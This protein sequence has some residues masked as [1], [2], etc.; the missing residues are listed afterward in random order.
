M[1]SFVKARDFWANSIASI[2]TLSFDLG[3]SLVPEHESIRKKTGKAG[4]SQA[5]EKIRI[6]SR[7]QLGKHG[8]ENWLG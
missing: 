8:K 5:A 7:K 6:I 4:Y 1:A 3:V 2:V